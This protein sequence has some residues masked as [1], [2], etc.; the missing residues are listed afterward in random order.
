M[1]APWTFMRTVPGRNMVSS[2]SDCTV[3]R[4]GR[5]APA[6]G[7]GDID[8]SAAFPVPRAEESSCVLDRDM[9]ALLGLGCSLA[10][11]RL[12]ELGRRTRWGLK[13]D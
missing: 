1:K 7:A 10:L 3:V 4:R 8:T 9:D 5:P 2:M 12:W 11:F 6:P 13:M